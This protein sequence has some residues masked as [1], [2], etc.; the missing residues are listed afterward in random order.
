MPL[1]QKVVEQLGREPVRTPGWSGRILMFSSTVFFIFVGLFAGMKFGMAT[2]L[3]DELAKV[4]E[5]IKTKGDEVT[6]GD[7]QSIQ[8]FYS[9]LSNVQTLLAKHLAPARL[10]DWLDAHTHENVWFDNASYNQT[11]NEVALNGTTATVPD[12]VQQ[13][14]HFEEQSEVKSVATRSLRTDKDGL[15]QFVMTV[16]FVPD[17]PLALGTE[18][19]GAFEQE[20][21]DFP[22]EEP[23]EFQSDTEPFVSPPEPEPVEAPSDTET[24]E[25]EETPEFP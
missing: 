14:L 17:F 19:D 2:Y 22:S 8:S 12:F 18:G 10:M 9:Q 3:E 21:S 20:P 5:Q 13:M 24:V 7:V 4:D 16:K 15:W 1:P 6:V 11:E 23:S 25:P